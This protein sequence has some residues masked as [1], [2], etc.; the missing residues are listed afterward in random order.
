[1]YCVTCLSAPNM[2]NSKK[3]EKKRATNGEVILVRKHNY[4]CMLD[5]GIY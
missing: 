4:N 2:E 3:K 1:M 5:D